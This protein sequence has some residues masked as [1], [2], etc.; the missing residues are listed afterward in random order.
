MDAS[1][2]AGSVRRNEDILGRIALIF[3]T[4][5]SAPIAEYTVLARSLIVQEARCPSFPGS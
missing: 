1:G 5:L 4:S 3:L 2:Y